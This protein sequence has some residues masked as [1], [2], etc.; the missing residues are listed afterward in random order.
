MIDTAV[1]RIETDVCLRRSAVVTTATSPEAARALH[2]LIAEVRRSG[3]T[4][5]F[6]AE[7]G[8]FLRT[9]QDH[10]VSRK[11]MWWLDRVLCWLPEEY[12]VSLLTLVKTRERRSCRRRFGARE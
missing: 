5:W 12:H 2:I 6:L 1:V 8:A 7:F 11:E 9:W 3:D 10:Y 4:T